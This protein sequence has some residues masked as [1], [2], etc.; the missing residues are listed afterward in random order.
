[1]SLEYG[2]YKARGGYSY[3]PSV[4]PASP[5]FQTFSRQGSGGL[6]TTSNHPAGAAHQPS[7]EID[8]LR[9]LRQ[10]QLTAEGLL[11][12]SATQREIRR[13]LA[14]FKAYGQLTP[15]EH[16]YLTQLSTQLQAQLRQFTPNPWAAPAPPPTAP[17]TALEFSRQMASAARLEAREESLLDAFDC[18]TEAEL[19]AC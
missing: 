4:K 2:G 19:E 16:H 13:V 17:V 3:S 7:A 8:L 11:L 10:G 14:R 6:T 15:Q 18:R 1:M 12:A 9:L 5:T